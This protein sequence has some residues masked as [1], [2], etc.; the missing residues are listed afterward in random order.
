[1]SVIMTLRVPG[2]PAALEQMAASEPDRISAIAERAKEY[3]VI[4]HRFYGSG[5]QIMVVDEWPDEDSF[6][7]FWAASES[8]IGPMMQQVATGEPE[9]RFWRELETG[10]AVGWES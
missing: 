8:E 1:M 6:N 10:D 4:G 7:R 9:V 3:G 5:D 2:D